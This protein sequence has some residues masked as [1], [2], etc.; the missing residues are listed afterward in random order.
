VYEQIAVAVVGG[1]VSSIVGGYIGAGVRLAVAE[2]RIARN[3][4]DIQGL[5]ERCDRTHRKG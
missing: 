4:T 5:S 1:L 2:S 3:E